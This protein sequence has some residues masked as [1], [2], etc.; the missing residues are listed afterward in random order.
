MKLG[1]TIKAALIGGA[2]TLIAALITLIQP[3]IT[4]S[5]NA[6]NNED[7]PVVVP[8]KPRMPSLDG[9]HENLHPFDISFLGI[10]KITDLPDNL[11]VSLKNL[12]GKDSNFF[13]LNNIFSGDYLFPHT[14]Q[15]VIIYATVTSK[16]LDLRHFD[17]KS[18]LFLS[19]IQP[20]GEILL[21]SGNAELLINFHIKFYD[22]ALYSSYGSDNIFEFL[23]IRILDHV[24]SFYKK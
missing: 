15:S 2:A 6:K 20:N 4:N 18:I 16:N 21:K 17:K 5:L 1:S 9:V 10:S 7:P 3:Y 12:N 22:K 19:K 8:N 14:N 13:V 11:Y 24:F 23:D